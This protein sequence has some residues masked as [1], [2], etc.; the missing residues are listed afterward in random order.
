M[1]KVSE[2][3]F[4]LAFLLILFVPFLFTNF[5]KDQVS[6]IDNTYLPELQ[7][8][9]DTPVGDR[10][11]DIENYLN[12]RIGFRDQMLTMYQ[13]LNDRLFNLMEHPLYMYGKNGYVYFGTWGYIAEYQNRDLNQAYADE[14]AGAMQAFSDLCREH[15]A[16]L[17]YLVIPD[18]KTIYPEYMPDGLNKQGDVS[19]IDQILHS[20]SETD[21]K[22]IF[23]YDALMEGKQRELVF[24]VKYDAGHWNYNGAF[25]GIRALYALMR[26]DH[27][28]IPMLREEAYDVST[29]HADT[30]PVSRFPINEEIPVYSLKESS[31]V[32][33]REWMDE[34]LSFTAETAYRTRYINPE[35]PDLPKLLVLHD[36]YFFGKE[37]FFTEN[38]SEVTFIHRENLLGT[39]ELKAYLNALHP[40]VVIIENPMTCFD[41]HYEVSEQED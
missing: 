3:C 40:D 16:D 27:P 10:I 12:A 32:S 22:W 26:I 17:Y 5:K 11:N 33:D 7:W 8:S 4:C 30:L 20:L 14:L 24:N 39:K 23:P 28:E 1:G 38:F 35:K 31:A 36:S 2:R 19:R 41:V 15:G 18:K 34:N 25:Y 21:V 37:L 29:E 9:G 13:I 6:E